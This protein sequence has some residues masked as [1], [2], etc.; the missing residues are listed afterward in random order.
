MIKNRI[1]AIFPIASLILG[2]AGIVFLS[3]PRNADSISEASAQ[4]HRAPRLVTVRPLLPFEGLHCPWKPASGEGA[5]PSGLMQ[6]AGALS[7]AAAEHVSREIDLTPVRALEDE[8]ATYSAVAVDPV[9]NE[10]AIQDENLFQIL[11]FDRL[12]NTPPSAT[13]TEPK[14][15]LSGP[16]TKIEFNCG[17]Y[18]DPKNGDIYSVNNDTTDTT[19]IFAHGQQG[20]VAPSRELHT[21]HGTYGIAVDETNGEMFFSI[22]H[23]NAVVAYEKMASGEDEPLRLIQ[24]DDT[25]LGDPHGIAVDPENNWLFVANHGSTHR[26]RPDPQKPPRPNWPLTRSF[27]VPGSGRSDPPSITIYERTAKGNA[28]PLRTIQGPRT[29]LNWPAQIYLDAERGE[30]FVANDGGNSVLVFRA[31]DDGDAAPVR[32]IA[33][34][35]TGLLNPTGVWADTVHDEVVVSSMGNHS[36]MVFPRDASGDVAPLR[37]I[38]SAP[39]GKRALAI[40]N[41]GAVAYDSKR[42]E[43]LV[44]N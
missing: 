27:A 13:M 22:E 8:Y 35:K 7:P 32:V 3:G 11:I 19:V 38:R 10:I 16:A 37:T 15:I 23:D 30:L 26:V 20:N 14:R 44:P 31:T 4:S 40:G 28:A 33:G 29:Q 9:R 34:P 12:A 21:P 41:P 36:A 43:L 2:S 17:L 42:D 25:G 5:I 6:A 1:V 39:L 18:I 24:G